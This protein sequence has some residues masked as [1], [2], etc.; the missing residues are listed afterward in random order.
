M[1]FPSPI[2]QMVGRVTV[3][4]DPL[5]DYKTAGFRTVTEDEIHT[6]INK[7]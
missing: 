2:F 4:T 1:D 6:Q 5:L 7:K 3:Q